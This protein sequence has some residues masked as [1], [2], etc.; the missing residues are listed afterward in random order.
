MVQNL[1]TDSYTKTVIPRFVNSAYREIWDADIWDDTLS[2][3]FVF[4]IPANQDTFTIPKRYSAIVRAWNS[5]TGE[6][7]KIKDF[8]T[9]GSEYWP[10]VINQSFIT[11]QNSIAALNTLGVLTQLTTPGT[12]TVQSSDA[13][14]TN[15]ADYQLQVL[16]KGRDSSG[17]PLSELI[18]LNGT[19]P[20]S[21][22]N[23]YAEITG[24]SK[25]VMPTE[26]VFTLKDTL[27]NSLSTLS[28]WEK[29]A[30]YRRYQI[31]GVQGI[32]TNIRLI[33]KQTFQPF[34]NYLD[35]P[36]MDLDNT[37]PHKATAFA[38][39]EN[40]QQD[41]AA[42]EEALYM[43]ELGKLRQREFS[44]ESARYMVPAMRG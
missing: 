20:V 22:V 32:I 5:D 13:D 16:V 12:V 29:T 11:G 27:G 33:C 18:S 2:T 28:Q 1:A 40:R 42:A 3:A 15:T 14:D 36:F 39:R 43:N 19:T 4:N 44:E 17:E 34:V 10:Q 38:W 35:Y 6:Q 21:S 26:G 24:F 41:L 9:F 23:T 25:Q 8:V 7:V 37:L 30:R 31:N